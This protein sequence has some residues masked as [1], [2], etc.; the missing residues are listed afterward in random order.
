[1]DSLET[2]LKE[3]ISRIRNS[4]LFLPS[5]GFLPHRQT[6][7]GYAAPNDPP[8]K[9][10]ITKRLIGYYYP[11]SGS[12]KNAIASL[13]L[14]GV[15]HLIYAFASIVNG[16]IHP[17]ENH[18]LQNDYEQLNLLKKRYP[19]LHIL[20]SVGGAGLSKQFSRVAGS[21]ITR[22]RFA[23][24]VGRFFQRWPIFEGLD[25][26]WEFPVEGDGKPENKGKPEDKHN[27]TLLVRALR[28]RLNKRYL[29]SLA[30]GAGSQ[31][32]DNIE[33]ANLAAEA[34]WILMMTYDY[35]NSP[36]GISG[37]NTPL[38]PDPS[39]PAPMREELRIENVSASILRGLAAGIPANKLYM[40]LAFYG[41]LWAQCNTGPRNN[42]EYQFC[43][44]R[45]KKN[46]FFNLKLIPYHDITKFLQQGAKQYFNPYT[47][48]PFL[49]NPEGGIFISYD[50]PVSLRAKIQWAQT[51]R[52]GGLGIWSLDDDRTG[53]LLNTVQDTWNKH[54]TPNFPKRCYPKRTGNDRQ[55]T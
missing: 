47:E 19:R 41:R 26:D 28:R 24:S 6:H 44:A 53:T 50:D 16:K 35:R 31:H 51:H 5:N 55:H 14:P 13:S 37:H 29:L 54:T 52:L 30:I 45:K 20:I 11:E 38:F 34:D 33:P 32:L 39:A 25:V 15:T 36:D 9:P 2:L 17:G 23:L 48:V 21:P 42:G 43:A 49:W 18:N 3:Y 46:E 8:Q 22:N 27:F 12:Q 40:G 4:P 10:K 7:H 1:M